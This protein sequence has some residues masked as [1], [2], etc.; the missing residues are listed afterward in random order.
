VAGTGL[1]P[2]GRKTY[3][4]VIHESFP[5][6]HLEVNLKAFAKGVELIH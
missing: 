2:L 4:E 3:E 5:G 1:L 6:A